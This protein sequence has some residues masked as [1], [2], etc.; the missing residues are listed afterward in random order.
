MKKHIYTFLFLLSF[1]VPSIAQKAYISWSSLYGGNEHDYN[2][3]S[4]LLPNG[5]FVSLG[6]TQSNIADFSGNKGNADI[7]LAEFDQNGQK[8][9][10]KLYG[11]NGYD[12]PR[13]I[14]RDSS[15]HFFIAGYSDSNTGDFGAS[16]GGNDFILLKTDSVGNLIW[17]KRYGGSGHDIGRGLAA[18]NDGFILSGHTLS[19]DSTANLPAKGISDWLVL[20]LDT[21]GN[22]VWRNRFGGSDEDTNPMPYV[23]PNGTIMLVGETKS[24]DGDINNNNGVNDIWTV[25][26][27]PGGNMLS[28][29]TAGGENWDQAEALVIENNSTFYIAGSSLSQTN[30]GATNKGGM[31]YWI[32]K[33]TFS[34]TTLWSRCYGSSDFDFASDIKLFNEKLYVLGNAGGGDEDVSRY[35]GADDFWLLE[36]DSSNGNLKLDLPLGGADFENAASLLIKPNGEMIITGDSYTGDLDLNP[37]QG[38]NDWLFIKIGIS[39]LSIQHYTNNNEYIYPNP[40]DGIFYIKSDAHKTYK[41]FDTAGQMLLDKVSGSIDL[42]SFANGMYFLQY[43]SEAP[44]KLVKNNRP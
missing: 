29:F 39:P 1:I 27:S 37:T 36:L 21:A 13:C 42:S 2:L 32:R 33:C 31:D 7:L 5:H 30:I 26:L 16:I 15:G 6:I 11:G 22:L 4:I 17:S 34:G 19:I 40:S 12:T 24:S 44:I 28:Q 8:L 38:Y 43:E 20:K 25:M 35:Y 41:L 10:H 14:I 18:V 3:Q 9:W 23:L